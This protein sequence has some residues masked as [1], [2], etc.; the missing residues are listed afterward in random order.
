[1]TQKFFDIENEKLFVYLPIKNAGKFRWKSRKTS[2]EYGEG[3]STAEIPYTEDS[4]VEWQIGYDVLISDVDSKP[5]SLTGITFVG[6]NGKTKHPYELS[7][8]LYGMI[9]ANIL[10]KDELQKL[11]S[12]VESSTRSLQDEFSIKATKVG[13]CDIDGI[14]C[15]EQ[16]I[17][18]PTFVYR[19]L[20][21]GPVIEISIQKQQ[22]ATGVQPML[23]IS[24]PVLSLENGRQYIGK[25]SKDF[26]NPFSV[27]VIDKNNKSY[28]LSIFRLFAICSSKHKHDV[29]E[30]LKK[31]KDYTSFLN[32]KNV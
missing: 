3:F 19:G 27:F 23:Y 2:D 9:K 28:I 18:L 1:M 12:E 25:T 15:D 31:I 13:E 11:I 10:S 20:N 6:A 29:D 8:I 26:K 32:D 30:I 24:I 7:E 5:T 21:N 4:Y 22:Y 17:S 14:R 16:I